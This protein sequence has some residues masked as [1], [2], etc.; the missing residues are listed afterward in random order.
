MTEC[1]LC[2]EPIIDDEPRLHTLLYGLVHWD[3]Y[4]DE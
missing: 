3:C 2:H 1:F 4:E